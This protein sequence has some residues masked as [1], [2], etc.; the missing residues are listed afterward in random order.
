MPERRAVVLSYFR[1]DES[2]TVVEALGAR[3]LPPGVPVYVGS[4]GIAPLLASRLAEL[5]DARYAPMFTLRP[6]GTWR[7][8]TLRPEDER[9]LPRASARW[10]GTIPA[11]RELLVSA[12]ATRVAWATELGR[13]LRD[14]L[15]RERRR[16]SKIPA[17]QFDEIVSQAAA[18]QPWRDLVRGV[19]DG[20]ALGREP[21]GD[22]PERG[23]VW[24]AHRALPLVGRHSFD[25]FWHSVDRAALLV[26]YEEYPS[27]VGDPR[28]AARAFDTAHRRFPPSLRA[29][30]AAGL[31][32]GLEV[33]PGLGGNVGGLSAA[34]VRRW[35]D[36]YLAGRAA[37][38][39]TAFAEFDLR[40]RNVE[41]AALAEVLRELARNLSPP[42]RNK[43]A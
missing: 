18:S 14:A 41:P 24:V 29:R 5:P 36:A 38:G 35:R 22:A 11:L 9:R 34:G 19:L 7:R 16:G 17:W 43:G 30:Y 32:P 31:T 21:L 3:I 2:E 10:R 20:L 15:R 37:A 6:S 40:G 13:R 42:P 23:V 1:A 25:R 28:E 27:F 12:P 39:V 33:R 26:A 4:Y 8:R